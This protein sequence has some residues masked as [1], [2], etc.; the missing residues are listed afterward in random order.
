LEYLI[1]RISGKYLPGDPLS[2][3]LKNRN[4]NST[5]FIHANDNNFRHEKSDS[6]PMKTVP[7]TANPRENGVDG[8]DTDFN[9][10]MGGVNAITN[11]LDYMLHLNTLIQLNDRKNQEF[12]QKRKIE[13][14]LKDIERMLHDLNS[15]E[16]V[17]ILVTELTNKYIATTDYVSFIKELENYRHSL[18]DR[19]LRWR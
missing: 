2:Y 4:K 5:T 14:M 12:L 16:T 10:S 9:N 18:V 11:P 17:Q 13:A 19:Y 6:S 8:K 3:R 1:G 15:T 7:Y